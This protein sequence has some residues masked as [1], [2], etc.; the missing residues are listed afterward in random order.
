M[1][2]IR[3]AEKNIETV[4]RSLCLLWEKINSKD[5]DDGPYYPDFKGRKK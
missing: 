1:V 5:N 4:R 3:G 2:F